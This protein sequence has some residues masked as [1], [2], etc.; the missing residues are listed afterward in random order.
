MVEQVRR[1]TAT[2]PATMQPLFDALGQGEQDSTVRRLIAL[3]GGDPAV[4]ERRVGEPAT[5]SRRLRFPSGGEIILHD[6][7][8]VAALLHV[9]PTAWAPEG[10]DLRPWLPRVSRRATFDQL[11]GALKAKRARFAGMGVPYLPVE[12]GHIR[13]DFTDGRGWK[14]PGNLSALA[15]TLSE[16]GRSVRPD[17]DDCPT[18]SDLLVRD[19]ATDQLDVERTV[20]ALDTALTSNLILEDLHWVRLADLLP[21]HMSELMERVESQ[22]T[23][24]SCRRILCFT[25]HRDSPP[26]AQYLSLDE[27]RRHRLELIPP[28]ELWG[29]PARIAAEAAAMQYVDHE[30]GAW[31]L[32]QQQGVL[33][34]QA[35]YN[36]SSMVDDSALIRLDHDETEDY[37]SGGR[38]SLAALARQINSDP[39]HREQ[40][41]FHSRD[42]FRGPDA[43]RLRDE[44]SVA[45]VNHTWL[46]Q[47]RSS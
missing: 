14:T 45:I 16:P 38:D 23:C 44:V 33:Y 27:A 17:D 21:L 7:V 12:G 31:F 8:V 46:A 18:C 37:R 13:L 11:V 24:T 35:R 47:E 42:L 41:R 26:T 3:F 28:V 25:L 19:G 10:V 20:Q 36:L 34:L 15:V 2:P 39:P 29:D 32:V 4:S 22:L 6:D 40:S 5:T 9:T 43:R 30:P 1:G